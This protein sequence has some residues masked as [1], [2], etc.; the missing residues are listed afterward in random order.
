MAF[1]IPS[2][3]RSLEAPNPIP[4]IAEM[5]LRSSE[6]SSRNQNAAADRNARTFSESMRSFQRGLALKQRKTEADQVH[7]ARKSENQRRRDGMIS[8]DLGGRFRSEEEFERWAVENRVDPNEAYQQF[9]QGMEYGHNDQQQQEL[10][11]INEKFHNTV[12]QIK[13]GGRIDDGT[14]DHLL[15]G[16]REVA[17][18]EKVA[19]RKDW[20]EPPKPAIVERARESILDPTSP[21]GSAFFKSRNLQPGDVVYWDGKNIKIDRKRGSGTNGE[22]EP[23]V[24]GGVRMQEGFDT[25]DMKKLRVGGVGKRLAYDLNVGKEPDEK[26][27]QPLDALAGLN[28]FQLDAQ[29]EYELMLSDREFARNKHAA[30]A[31]IKSRY[32]SGDM[33][34]DADFA[35]LESY[36]GHLA[37]KAQRAGSLSRQDSVRRKLIQRMM[38]RG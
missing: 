36:L 37:I 10:K 34:N 18:M 31:E 26:Q 22:D 6:L 21:E 17:E 11:A 14:M 20:Y 13:E 28:E 7:E 29:V 19:V 33:L 32:D 16:A 35:V 9:S 25:E 24:I 4:K 2:S 1:N 27:V 38:P 5:L 8:K 23:Y 3:G 30:I 12:T 15:S